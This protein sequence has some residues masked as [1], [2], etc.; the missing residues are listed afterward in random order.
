MEKNENQKKSLKKLPGFYIALCC[1]VL[2]IGLAGYF[3]ERHEKNS[4][5]ADTGENTVFSG[6]IDAYTNDAVNG[7]VVPASETVTREEYDN[8]IQTAEAEAAATPVPNEA[9]NTEPAAESVYE[10]E[11]P[12]AEAAVIVSAKSPDLEMP[13]NGD[14]LAEF[15]DK[16]VYNSAL[17]D[18]RTH[19]G[20]DIAADIGCSVHAAASGTVRSVFSDAMG[21]GVEIEHEDGFVTRY[22]GLQSLEN[23]KE[24]DAVQ[25]GDVIGIIGESK[26]ESTEAAHLHFEVYKEGEATDPKKYLE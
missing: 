26:G 17:E 18:W 10:D 24:G 22:A 25:S 3:T 2:V 9:A 23:L 12:A 5:P 20:I 21:E 6:D 19:N 11:A 15:S 8:E 7:N 1:C 16:L 4:A 14:I 13:V